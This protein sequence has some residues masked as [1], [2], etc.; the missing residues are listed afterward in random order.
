MKT[1]A[2]LGPEGSHALEAAKHYN[3]EAEIKLYP[4]IPAVLDALKRGETDQAIIPVYNTREGEIKEF[5]RLMTRVNG[6]SWIDNVVLPIKLSLGTLDAESPVE[7][8]IGRASDLRQCEDYIA[9]RFPYISQM[10]VRDPVEA[11]TDITCNR[12]RDR[13]VIST[14]ET[15][16]AGGLAVREREL[17]P[18]NRTRF[19][20]LSRQEAPISG[21]DATALM[22]A[23]LKDRVGLLY[24]MLGEFTRRGVNLLDMRSET[25]IKTQE[26]QIY[27]EAEGH[28][29]DNHFK[30]AIANI[31]AQVI[32]EPGSIMLLGSFP[33]V[34]M[35]TKHIQA[36][37]F[38]GS[39]AMSTWFAQRLNNEGYRSIITG[40][41][42]S[43]RPEEM[44]P[45]VDVVIICVPI[46]ATAAT[47]EKYGPLLTDGQA[48]ILLAGE[49]E[50]TLRAAMKHTGPGVEVMFVHN[51]WGPQAANMKDKNAAVVRT[52]KSGVL[53]SEFESFLY[54]H[55][56][57]IFQDTAAHHDLLIGFSQKLP[58][59]ISVALA[60]TL[61]KNNIEGKDID[62]HSTLTSLYSV[63]AMARLH[64]QNPR[65]YAEIM[66]AMGNSRKI[67][68]DFAENIL[69]VLELAENE[70]ID[71][72]CAIIE[73]NREYLSADFLEARMQQALAIDETLMKIRNR[74]F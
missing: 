47:I 62:S 58:S 63:L 29:R 14:E 7:M 22:T 68:R 39:G 17:A 19:A 32:Q 4:L 38:I 73:Q 44:I 1:I 13:G 50:N 2:T 5:F 15:L 9:G 45:Q 26:L 28:M 49:A 24:D 33:R 65:T 46:S 59:L 8:L 3:P 70:K 56:A 23:P 6:V 11:I 10:A 53:C 35:R 61:A 37:G 60:M 21:Y 12:Y 66:A 72:L 67:A 43:V 74:R 69:A 57:A 48:L 20:V 16:R 54:K 25:D 34:D 55:G 41:S 36:F 40:R 18:Y 64:T 30:Q 42:S 52:N 27:I 31:E 71:A 51:L